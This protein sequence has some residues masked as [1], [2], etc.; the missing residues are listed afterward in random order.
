MQKLPSD[1]HRMNLPGRLGWNLRLLGLIA[2]SFFPFPASG[3]QL[4][5]RQAV[6]GASS[7]WA[8]APAA[9][10]RNAAIAPNPMPNTA[11]CDEGVLDL[12]EIAAAGTPD[13]PAEFPHP[14]HAPSVQPGNIRI[15]V[16]S[17]GAATATAQTDSR[18]QAIACAA[19][20]YVELASL[21]AQLSLLHKQE[22]ESQRLLN[23]EAKR[24]SVEVDDPALLTRARLLAAETHMW[25][26]AL[27][28][29]A[30]RARQGL[31]GLLNVDPQDISTDPNSIPPIPQPD[32]DDLKSYELLDQLKANR[33]VAQLQYVAEFTRRLSVTKEM[34][35]GR[36]SIADLLA[37]HIAEDQRFLLLLHA[38]LRLSRLRLEVLNSA[39]EIESWAASPPPP[40][41]E[42]TSGRPIL[43]SSP[44]NGAL[45]SILIT[46]G[47]Q[48]LYAGTSRQYRAFAIYEDGA[49]REETSNALWSLNSDTVAVVSNQGVV[50][51]LLAGRMK[52]SAALHGVTRWLTVI[53][54]DAPEDE[55]L[56]TGE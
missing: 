2:L 56:R 45:L 46:P 17:D 1:G 55:Y 8:P 32:S 18:E 22:A 7:Q 15:H 49:V 33:D 3:S 35:L 21:D 5:L 13:T 43:A 4:T 9:Q 53:I 37:A 30:R 44:K 23:I 40:T 42:S 26:V 36:A 31:A 39:V 41:T 28:S 29:S 24:V 47:A 20:L 51:A 52:I 11:R 27:Q 50:T 54:P 34:A 16:Q 19:V 14:T 38:N 25:S 12:L 10:P 48:E 6:E